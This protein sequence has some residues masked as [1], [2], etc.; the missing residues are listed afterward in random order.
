MSNATTI[1]QLQI[2]VET[3]AEGAVKGLK[4]LKTAL[5][6]VDKIAKSNGLDT[7]CQKLE[8]ISG[9]DFSN[10]N[11]LNALGNTLRQ[12]E[13][14]SKKVD[15]LSS[16][17]S[18]GSSTMEA[19]VDTGNIDD[20]T[21]KVGEFSNAMQQTGGVTTAT[22]GASRFSRVMGKVRTAVST[23]TTK[24]RSMS[25]RLR[26]VAGSFTKTTK[27]ASQL[28]QILRIVVLYGG[29]FRLFAMLTQ[30]VSEG[31]QNVAKYNE[32]TA[33]AMSRLSTMALYLKNSIGAAL[34]PV[35][36]ALTP[37]LQ[38]MTNAVV[39]A[40]EGL[41]QLVSLLSGKTTYLKAKEYLKEYGDTA[42]KTA[43]K[44]KKSFAG[45][46]EITVIGQKDDSSSSEDDFGAMFEEVPIDNPSV[47]ALVPFFKGLG[48][49][50]GSCFNAIKELATDH[51]Y[52]WLVKLGD[53]A[54][55]HPDELEDIGEG[56]ATVAVALVA[57]K[58]AESV[59]TPL[60][61]FFNSVGGA[62]NGIGILGTVAG[63]VVQLMGAFDS[64]EIG[65]AHV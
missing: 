62:K 55:E 22:S 5:Q 54:E 61:N 30:G 46:D 9:L 8:K 44:I 48:T 25:S 52:P 51:L 59:I 6:S 33:S 36:V 37:A 39:K 56:L 65:R 43:N 21:H 24:I 32:E 45:F 19:N 57:M 53:W 47:Q 34:Y 49:V 2:E 10:L 3:K 38:A 23:A 20:A 13:Q 64:W 7:V 41:G 40:F 31:L 60:S 17:L 1:D 35:I 42:S 28:S 15:A 63:A 11:Q 4:S 26:E 58:G 27:K 29:A 18:N 12:V 14:L 16:S 50:L